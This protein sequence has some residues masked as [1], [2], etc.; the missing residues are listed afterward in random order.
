MEEYEKVFPTCLFRDFDGILLGKIKA[1]DL[2]F[3]TIIK[4]I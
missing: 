4:I 1:I 2:L 3:K